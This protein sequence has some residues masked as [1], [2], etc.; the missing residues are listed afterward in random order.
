MI[1][2]NNNRINVQISLLS[3]LLL[4]TI[5]ACAEKN[6]ENYEACVLKETQK[7]SRN[8]GD[9]SKEALVVVFD[10]CD[11]YPSRDA[12]AKKQEAP[13]KIAY[14]SWNIVGPEMGYFD[15]KRYFIDLNNVDT[16]G[17]EKTFWIKQ[18]EIGDAFDGNTFE[19]RR[20]T[21]NC[22]AGTFTNLSWKKS[23]KGKS[24]GEENGDFIPYTVTPGSR[25][26]DFYNF[27]CE[28]DKK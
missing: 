7:M 26:S 1:V 23:V 9:I 12:K 6:Y 20:I 14:P 27:I 24:E 17:F 22:A 15:G 16:D 5:S 28:I 25:G 10:Y 19:V 8:N 13:K 11:K 18:V 2:T 4:L 21:A 3:G